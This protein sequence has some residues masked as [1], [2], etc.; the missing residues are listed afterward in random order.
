[1]V[2]GFLNFLIFLKAFQAGSRE[3]ARLFLGHKK[4]SFSDLSKLVF[5][6]YRYFLHIFQKISCIKQKSA[7]EPTLLF[8]SSPEYLFRYLPNA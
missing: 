1:V 8:L 2:W 6:N 7:F 5:P 3:Y 4:T